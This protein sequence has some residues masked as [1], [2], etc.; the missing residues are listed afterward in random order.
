MRR[1]EEILE[2]AEVLDEAAD[3]LATVLER[4]GADQLHPPET[5]R[6]MARYELELAAVDVAALTFGTEIRGSWR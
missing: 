2:V 1:A 5:L 3:K 4:S 6:E